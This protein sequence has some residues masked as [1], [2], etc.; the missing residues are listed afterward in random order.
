MKS[1]FSLLVVPCSF[2]MSPMIW[3]VPEGVGEHSGSKG[4]STHPPNAPACG[5]GEGREGTGG[6]DHS[7]LA[8]DVEGLVGMPHRGRW[9]F[10]R[11][12]WHSCWY[13]MIHGSPYSK[14][15]WDLTDYGY[16]FG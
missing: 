16:T 11:R 7:A 4:A 15:A 5:H 14:S 12:I 3:E 8:Q 13:E 1:N 9:H 2:E 6:Q 10:S